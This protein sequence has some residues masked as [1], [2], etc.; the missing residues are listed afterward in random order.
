MITPKALSMAAGRPSETEIHKICRSTRLGQRV[1][2]LATRAFDGKLRRGAR[3]I[4]TG[5]LRGLRFYVDLPRHEYFWFG[6]FEPGVQQAICKQLRPGSI[7]WDV[8]AFTRFH[9]LLLRKIARRAE[10]SLLNLIA[11]TGASFLKTYV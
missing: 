8:G 10:L 5:P 2:A 4:V 9:T 3:A 1:V 7:A 6:T 11:K